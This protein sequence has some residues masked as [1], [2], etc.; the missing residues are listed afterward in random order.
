MSRLAMSKAWAGFGIIKPLSKLELTKTFYTKFTHLK[1]N[2]GLPKFNTN[3]LSMQA[4]FLSS[5]GHF[6]KN[7]IH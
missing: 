3:I 6:M 5:I 4:K 7:K 2:L 1:Y